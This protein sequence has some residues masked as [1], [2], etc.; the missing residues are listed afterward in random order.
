MATAQ[1]Y[2]SITLLGGISL[3]A[4]SPGELTSSDA[5]GYSIGPLI[6]WKLPFTTPARARVKAAGAEADGSLARF[7]QSVLLALQESEQALARLKGSVAR[8]QSLGRA[9]KASE[10]AA[11]ISKLR[12]DYGAD[13]L[14]Q[15]LDAER[16]RALARAE[17]AGSRADRATAQ[18]SVL[19]GAG[20]RL[21]NRARTHRGPG[22][23]RRRGT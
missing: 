14:F 9:L 4:G 22:N 11:R 10:S 7:D 21:A 6:S 5:L 20:R 16:E 8:E 15:L 3:G 13:S 19:Q 18:I 23:R 2:P 1:L 12:F 17:F